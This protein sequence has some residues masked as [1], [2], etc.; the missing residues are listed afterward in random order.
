VGLGHLA[1]NFCVALSHRDIMQLKYVAG[2]FV[3]LVGKSIA[4]C[5]AQELLERVVSPLS[6]FLWTYWLMAC[7]VAARF[8]RES[9]IV[10]ARDN[11]GGRGT[12]TLTLTA[13]TQAMA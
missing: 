11:G 12:L 10:R 1:S 8:D 9:R 13:A 6:F 5:L 2:Q 7:H 3:V 4:I